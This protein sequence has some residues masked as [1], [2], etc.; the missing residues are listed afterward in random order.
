M[1]W[2]LKAG[3][4]SFVTNL[5]R[6]DAGVDSGG[7]VGSQRFDINVFD[8]CASLHLKNRMAMSRLLD[9]HLPSILDGTA[10]ATPQRTDLE[11]TYLPKRTPDDG[12]IDWLEIDMDG[13]YNHVRCQTRPFPG[14]FSHLE[15]GEDRC[16]FWRVSPFDT[17][18]DFPGSYPGTVAEVF[19]D[20]TFLV[21]VWDGSVRVLDY[22][23]PTPVKGQRFGHSQDAP[24]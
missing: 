23:G 7:I 12:R 14:A 6:Y 19:H 18:I 2:A 8:D 16:Y 15:G 11:P 9:R 13:L 3:K 1:N 20:N 10:T 24:E 17:H 21:T 5:F 22:E 4:T